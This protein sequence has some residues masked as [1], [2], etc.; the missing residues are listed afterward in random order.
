M[1]CQAA[2]C[3]GCSRTARLCRAVLSTA[4]RW[5]SASPLQERLGQGVRPDG[6]R[7]VLGIDVEERRGLLSAERGEALPDLGQVAGHE[8]QMAHGVE[9]RRCLGGDD[10]AVAMSNHDGRLVARGQDLPDGGD[11]VGQPRSSCA[12][13]LTHLTA[14]REG[15]RLAGDA[16]LGQQLSGAVPPPR[17]IFDA[18]PVHENDPHH[19]LL[20]WFPSAG[21]AMVDVPLIT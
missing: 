11:I 7:P 13:R 6:E 21:Q 10:P 3:T 5:I 18:C 20:A 8:Q 17:S 12:G 19:D 9:A 14:A 2:D 1:C 4:S 15:R 16:P